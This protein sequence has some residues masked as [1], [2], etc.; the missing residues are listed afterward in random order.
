V[1]LDFAVENPGLKMTNFQYFNLSKFATMKESL[2]TKKQNVVRMKE[3]LLRHNI[4][5]LNV[6]RMQN[7]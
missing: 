1:I 2:C 4:G 7:L 5:S 3:K 6:L